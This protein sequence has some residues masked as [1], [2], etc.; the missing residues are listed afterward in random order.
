LRVSLVTLKRLQTVYLTEEDQQWAQAKHRQ[1]KL[2]HN[3]G[4][5]D[6]LIASVSQRLELPLY[7]LNLKHMRPVLGDLAVKPY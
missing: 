4:L 5:A 1:Y 6:C 2:S 3:V 7:T